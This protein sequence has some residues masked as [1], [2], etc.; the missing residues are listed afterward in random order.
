MNG[1]P[2]LVRFQWF[3]SADQDQRLEER[4]LRREPRRQLDSTSQQYL[5]THAMQD[6]P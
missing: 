6:V 4:N 3:G 2:Y 1:S 5:S